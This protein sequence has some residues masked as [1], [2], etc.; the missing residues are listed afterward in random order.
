M[1]VVPKLAISKD[2]ETS[3]FRL[4]HCNEEWEDLCAVQSATTIEEI[5]EIAEKHYQ[6]INKNWIRTNYNESDAIALIEAEKEAVEGFILQERS[7]LWD[8]E[9]GRMVINEKARICELCIK[10]YYSF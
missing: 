4:S 2:I 1:G 6:G 9:I 8:E 3:E 10:S 7:P 5:K